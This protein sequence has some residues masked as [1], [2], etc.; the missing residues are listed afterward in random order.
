MIDDAR[1]LRIRNLFWDA[2]EKAL[3]GR[4]DVNVTLTTEGNNGT[5]FTKVTIVGEFQLSF[6]VAAND[7]VVASGPKGDG[8]FKLLFAIRANDE[9]LAL[10]PK[11][12]IPRCSLTSESIEGAIKDE[13]QREIGPTP[14]E[15]G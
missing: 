3:A 5:V 15:S 2:V 11:G 1:M 8:D 4:R 14:F 9:V 10:G 13:I 12:P 6:V 7:E